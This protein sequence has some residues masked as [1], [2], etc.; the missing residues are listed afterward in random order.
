MKVECKFRSG[1]DMPTPHQYIHVSIR[2]QKA[3]KYIFT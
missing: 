3:K 2:G 1:G